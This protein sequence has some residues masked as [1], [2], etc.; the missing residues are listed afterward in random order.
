[1]KFILLILITVPL[2]GLSQDS[3]GRQPETVFY[4]IDTDCENCKVKGA[5]GTQFWLSTEHVYAGNWKDRDALVKAFRDKLSGFLKADSALLK[6]VVFRY[7]DTVQEAERSIADK[8][9]KMKAKGYTVIKFDF[10][11][12]GNY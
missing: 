4:F 7:Q 6:R 10:E 1:M 11:P 12:K 3:A 9:N 5:E 2:H 8:E